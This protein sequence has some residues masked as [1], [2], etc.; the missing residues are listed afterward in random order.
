MFINLQ[1]ILNMSSILK[2]KH[3]K[4]MSC[5]GHKFH[6]KRLDDKKKTFDCGIT[7]VFQVTHVSY[8]SDKHPKG[9]YGYLDDIFECEFKSFK[10]VL[11]KV[12]WYR[13]Q[14]NEREPK[15]IVIEHAN[16][17]TMI[18]TRILELGIEPYVLPS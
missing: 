6:I 7:I 15:R 4:G 12:N 2:L 10:L 14:M 5:N 16:G 9:Y 11:F 13:L 3:H 1:C 17:F 8:R 18:N